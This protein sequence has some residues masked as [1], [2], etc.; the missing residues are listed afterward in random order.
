MDMTFA[1]CDGGMAVQVPTQHTTE[2]K[3]FQND[4][5]RCTESESHHTRSSVADVEVF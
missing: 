5:L 3:R 2:Y 4:P 1:L